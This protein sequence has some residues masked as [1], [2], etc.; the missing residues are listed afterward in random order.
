MGKNTGISWTD[1]TWNPW[2][3]CTP[4]ASGCTWCYARRE[5]TRY[6][7]SFSTVTRTKPATFNLPLKLAPGTRV[8]VCSWSDFFHPSADAWRA[9]AWG[10]IRRRP[11]LTFIIPTKRPG[12]VAERTPWI[13][14]TRIETVAWDKPWPHVWG[15]VSASTQLEVDEVVPKLLALPFAVR[16]VS[17]EPLLGSV[18]LIGHIARRLPGD[19]PAWWRRGLH[20]AI[21]AGESG[22]PTERRLVDPY[23]EDGEALSGYVPKPR[24]LAWVRFLRDQCQAAGTAFHFKGW[25]GPRPDSGGRFL[26]GREWLEFPR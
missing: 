11:D 1:S 13:M 20:W 7:R 23:S 22:G 14:R 6:G 26:D 3:G 5:M 19:P 10:I 2:M 21:V 12:N 24:A 15:L 8:F 17:L 4:V 16:G 25:G 9:E 18:D